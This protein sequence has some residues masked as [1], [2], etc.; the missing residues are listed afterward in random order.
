MGIEI[1]AYLLQITCLYSGG[2]LI[3]TLSFSFKGTGD[4]AWGV[5]Y[6]LGVCS[7]RSCLLETRQRLE[8]KV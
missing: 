5:C 8:R 4:R 2:L 6:P 7:F 1:Q 3:F